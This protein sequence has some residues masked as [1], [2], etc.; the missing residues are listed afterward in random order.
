MKINEIVV[1]VGPVAYEKGKAAMDK[2]LNPSQWFAGTKAQQ[3][4]N[5]GADAMDKAL[6][7]SRWLEPSDTQKTTNKTDQMQDTTELK[8]VVDV[9]LSGKPLDAKGKQTVKKY[10]SDIDSDVKPTFD[11]LLADRQ[12]DSQD[13]FE[14]KKYRNNI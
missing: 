6:S 5:K 1:E 14:L 7:P 4:F 2:V 8:A 9:A 10:Y 12:L 3:Q 13:M 11:K